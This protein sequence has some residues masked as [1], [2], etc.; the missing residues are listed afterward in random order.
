[1]VRV[2]HN[3][4]YFNAYTSDSMLSDTISKNILLDKIKILSFI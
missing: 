3:I 2:F 4:R 1:M